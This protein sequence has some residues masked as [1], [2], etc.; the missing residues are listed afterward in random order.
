MHIGL[1]DTLENGESG[2]GFNYDPS[3]SYASGSQS[4]P[5]DLTQ[6]QE[7]FGYSYDGDGLGGAAKLEKDEPAY[8]DGYGEGEGEGEEEDDSAPIGQ[9]DYWTVISAYFEGK[10]LVRQ[11]LESFNEF[12]EN[13]IQEIVDENSRLTLDQYTQYTGN[14]GDETV[15]RGSHLITQQ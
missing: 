15:G 10:G 13:T 1:N 11:Q 2:D 14:Q 6:E 5:Q 9:E 4:Q 3:Y 12:V 8:G 7:G